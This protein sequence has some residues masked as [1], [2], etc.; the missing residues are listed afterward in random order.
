MNLQDYLIDHAGIDWQKLFANWHWCISGK[1]T[2]WIIN[3]FGDLFIKK[4]DGRI[5]WL[6][7]DDGSLTCVAESK[8]DF[9]RKMDDPEVANDWLMIP[10]VDRLVAA[11]KVLEDGQCYAFVQ[12]PILGGDYTVENVVVRHLE[13]QFQALGPIFEKLKDVPDGTRVNF[14]IEL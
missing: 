9:S 4:E 11:G 13:W 1:F 10:L 3:R 5:Y 14:R 6:A 8:D 12:L 7:L 2:V